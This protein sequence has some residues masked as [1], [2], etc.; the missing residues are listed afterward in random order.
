MS[1]STS[2]EFL[3][4]MKEGKGKGGDGDGGQDPKFIQFF[5]TLFPKDEQERR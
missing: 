2:D 5:R 3:S 4:S 1:E